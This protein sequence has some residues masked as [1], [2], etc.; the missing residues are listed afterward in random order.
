M[1]GIFRPGGGTV[2][3]LTP[4]EILFGAAGGGIGQST[5]FIFDELSG[6]LL[7]GSLAAP[8]TSVASVVITATDFSGI[9]LQVNAPAT[10]SPSIT[11]GDTSAISHEIFWDFNDGGLKIAAVGGPGK[12]FEVSA[13]GNVLIGTSAVDSG[14]QLQLTGT[15]RVDGQST[16]GATAPL[17]TANKP[18]ATNAIIGW[19]AV[20]IDGTA[21]IIPVWSA[22]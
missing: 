20:N 15:L 10:S 1:G 11:F 14:D 13:A 21:G 12:L 3:G 2:S 4:T 22:A 17:L 6:T 9:Q 8:L 7:V 16:V 5:D 19:M 18:G